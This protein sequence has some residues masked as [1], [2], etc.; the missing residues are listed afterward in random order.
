MCWA[1]VSL[2]VEEPGAPGRDQPLGQSVFES[3]AMS[4]YVAITA[5]TFR[6]KSYASSNKNALDGSSLEGLSSATNSATGSW[7]TS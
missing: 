1:G 5:P 6:R 3:W 2:K 4:S 7:K